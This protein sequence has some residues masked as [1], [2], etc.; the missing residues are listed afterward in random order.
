MDTDSDTDTVATQ[1]AGASSTPRSREVVPDLHWIAECGPDRSRFVEDDGDGEGDDAGNSDLPAWYDPEEALHVPQCA[2]LFTDERSLLFDTLSPASTDSILAAL[3]GL[4]DDGLDYLVVS[5]PDVPHAGNTAAILEAYPDA[6]LVA[7]AYG[8]GHELYHLDEATHVAEGDSLDLGRYTV[9]FHEAT[10]LDAALH[11]W[12]SER[13]TGTLFPVDW[14][15]YPHRG[16]ECLAF[17]D[18]LDPALDV[19]RLVQFHGRVLFWFQYVDVEAVNDEVDRLMA[20]FEPDIIAPAHGNVVREDVPA[21]VELMK[22]VVREI[23]RQG[24]VGTLG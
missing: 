24:R 2:Y 13:E 20:N 10:F 18:E 3:S 7:P 21:Q 11:C 23:D 1:S 9:D 4:L 16:D 5:H 8:V 15:G 12:M 14:F 17:A 6:E 22:E 19:S